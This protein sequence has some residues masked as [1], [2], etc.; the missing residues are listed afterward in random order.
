MIAC[1]DWGMT[2]AAL[3]LA[4]STCCFALA[5]MRASKDLKR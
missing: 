1:V 2:V 4:I 5:Y 3:F